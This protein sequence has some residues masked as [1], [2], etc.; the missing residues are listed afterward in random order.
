PF[1]R[2]VWVIVL[3]QVIGIPLI[4]GGLGLVIYWATRPPSADKLYAQA[5]S[6]WKTN[7]PENQDKA[8]SGPIAEY[9]RYYPRQND[10]HSQA[11]QSWADQYD[12]RQREKQLANRMHMSLAPQDDGEA[13][14]QSAVRLEETGDLEGALKRWNELLAYQGSDAHAWGLLARSRS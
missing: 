3:S 8:R 4:L 14:A 7:D 10:E 12:L 1:Y 11:I 2:K 6:L 13:L 5:E 9:L